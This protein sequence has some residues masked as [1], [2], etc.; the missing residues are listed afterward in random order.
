MLVVSLAHSDAGHKDGAG[1]TRTVLSSPPEAMRLPLGL[2]AT[3]S[4]QPVWPISGAPICWPVSASHTRSVLSRL[5]DTIR[6]PSG[7]NATLHTASVWPVSGWPVSVSHTRT[8]L[9]PPE[10]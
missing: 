10:R 6:R 2:N 9:S 3:L 7:L 4:T 1:H 5:A 8:V